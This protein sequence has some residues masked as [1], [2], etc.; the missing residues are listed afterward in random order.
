MQGTKKISTYYQSL[1]QKSLSR[2]NTQKRTPIKGLGDGVVSTLTRFKNLTIPPQPCPFFLPLYFQTMLTIAP[3][4][5]VQ[6]QALL[7]SLQV[8]R[9]FHAFGAK[10]D[11]VHLT[12]ITAQVLASFR[13]FSSF[14]I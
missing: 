3:A 10:D 1:F 6:I 4:Q 9:I 8:P 12:H 14:R 2:K 11:A 5:Q 13:I 7:L